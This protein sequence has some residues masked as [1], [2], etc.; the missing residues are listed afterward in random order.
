MIRYIVFFDP[1]KQWLNHIFIMGSN[2]SICTITQVLF[3]KSNKLIIDIFFSWICYLFWF[4]V[5]SFYNAEIHS[6]FA[7]VIY[8]F[9]RSIEIRLDDQTDGS[10]SKLS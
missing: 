5:S 2:R 4:F 3:Y 6:L 1:S 7:K 10:A 9:F 8:V